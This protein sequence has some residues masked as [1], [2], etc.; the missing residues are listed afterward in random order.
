MFK[1]VFV[2]AFVRWHLRVWLIC[3]TFQ[4][5]PVIRFT[6][7]SQAI[8]KP[9]FVQRIEKRLPDFCQHFHFPE[10]KRQPFIQIAFAKWIRRMNKK[11]TKQITRI[12]FIFLVKMTAHKLWTVYNLRYSVLV[13]HPVTGFRHSNRQFRNIFKCTRV[14]LKWFIQLIGVLCKVRWSDSNK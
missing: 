2:F 13:F 4:L 10:M 3:C 11:K 5:T 9:L 12:Y 6:R 7:K 8:E 1:W 14:P